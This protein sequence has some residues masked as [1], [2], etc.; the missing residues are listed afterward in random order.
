MKKANLD[1]ENI[2]FSYRETNARYV[3]EY[4]DGKWCEGALIKDSSI[5]LNESAGVFQYAQTIFEGLKAFETVNG[6]IVTFRPDLNAERFVA[7]AKRLEMA[8]LPVEQFL[9]GIDEVIAANAAYV[10]PYGCGASLYIRPFMYGSDPVIGVS[11]ATEYQFR[12][13]TLPVGPYF[14]GGITPLSLLVSEFDRAAPRGTGNV[15]A[16]LNYA[17]SMHAIIK[18]REGGFA[19]S[20]YL[21]HTR[22]KVEETSGANF[23]FVTKDKKIVTPLSNTIL[24]SITRRSLLH[25]AKEHLGLE[26]EEREVYVDELKDFAECGVCG[27][28]TVLAPIGRIVNGNQEILFPSGMEKMGEITEKMRNTLLDIQHGIIEAPKG[29]IRK[30]HLE[31]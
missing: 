10:P 1:W 8:V 9:K 20:M 24:P 18:A 21:D 7:S 27:T 29:W 15:K 25:V 12:I 16:G 13:F 5:V 11:P 19:D 17:M 30:I 14:R 3:S 6:D 2:G 31:P 26:V 4:K 22:T 23:L 28:A